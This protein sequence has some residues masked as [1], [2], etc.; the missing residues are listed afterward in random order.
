[1][2]EVVQIEVTHRFQHGNVDAA[3]AIGFHALMQSAQ[4]AECR[5]HSG[6][7]IGDRGADHTRGFPD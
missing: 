4:N 2:G 6:H 7:C 1:M 5:I 3:A